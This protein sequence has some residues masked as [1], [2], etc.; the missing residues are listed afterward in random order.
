MTLFFGGGEGGY[1]KCHQVSHGG[2]VR[3]LKN[4]KSVTYYLC[5]TFPTVKSQTTMLSFLPIAFKSFSRRLLR[6]GEDSKSLT[7]IVDPVSGVVGAVLVGVSSIAPSLVFL[8]F[9]FIAIRL[10]RKNKSLRYKTFY[11]QQE[12]VLCK[13]KYFLYEL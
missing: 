12:L 2:R 10:W 3:S 4:R 9:T 7:E 1:P 8:P 5:V 11:H 13:I 6:V